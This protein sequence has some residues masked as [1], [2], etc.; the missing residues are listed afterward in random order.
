VSSVVDD[1]ENESHLKED[2]EWNIVEVHCDSQRHAN[3]QV[4]VIRKVP[5]VS[6]LMSKQAPTNVEVERNS[7]GFRLGEQASVR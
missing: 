4:R 1:V 6:T 2:V 3:T 5:I 7:E